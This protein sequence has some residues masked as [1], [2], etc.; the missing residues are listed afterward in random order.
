MQVSAGRLNGK[1]VFIT[2]TAGG[3][4]RAAARLFAAE[5]ARVVGCDLKETDLKWID[6]KAPVDLAE[7][8]AAAEWIEW[9]VGIA[10]GIDILYNNASAPR[11]GPWEEASYDDW[12]F[13]IRNEL[14]L[15]YTV[16]KAAWPH[17][18]GMPASADGVRVSPGATAFT[19]IPAGPSSGASVRTMPSRAALLAT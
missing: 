7:P 6:S 19:V 9:G 12:R 4:G 11:V 16:T 2:G 18:G 13:T 8:E 1:T 17:S 10:G 14:D 3:Q 15:I 5:G